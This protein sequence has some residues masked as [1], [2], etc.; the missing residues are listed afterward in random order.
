MEAADGKQLVTGL[1][2]KALESQEKVLVDDICSSSSLDKQFVMGI[3]ISLRSADIVKIEGG[4]KEERTITESGKKCI[5]EGSPE[6]RAYKLLPKE[7]MDLDEIEK[8]FPGDRD[9]IMKNIRK[10]GVKFSK[11][12]GKSVLV[13]P[14]KDKEGVEDIVSTQLKQFESGELTDNKVITILKKR[15]LVDFK[16]VNLHYICRGDKFD[17]INTRK[18]FVPIITADLIAKNEW[19]KIQ[20]KP[21]NF[22]A[23]GA[24]IQ[25]GYY[26]PLMQMRS[27]YKSFLLSMGFIEMKTNRFVESSFWNFD[28]LIQPQQHAARDMQDTFFVG[29]EPEALKVCVDTAVSATLPP[30]YMEAVKEMHEKGG[31]GSIG[32]RYTWSE[33]EARKNILRTHTTAVSARTLYRLKKLA[34]EGYVDGKFFSIDRVFRNETLDATHLAEFHQV[35][36]F[37][38]GKDLSL[39]DLMRTITTFFEKLG[40]HDISFKYAYNPYTEPSMEIFAKHP[41]LKGLIEVGNSGVFRP[42]M[43]RPMGFPEGVNVIAW[44]LSL[45]RP[46]MILSNIGNIRELFGP[47]VNLDM[48]VNDHY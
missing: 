2:A 48:L 23:N 14:E 19:D 40:M 15:G 24:P 7:G 13:P 30:D 38:I 11:V 42:E 43:L 18:E 6:F 33:A 35:E 39:A 3:A 44:G 29:S 9:E 32:Y 27:L 31:Y 12:D 45:E 41:K 22:E 28:A 26:H 36:G 34:G 46:K 8:H 4:S 1:I 47:N 20:L 25:K 17:E 37:I 5:E 10:Y 16:N 21:Y